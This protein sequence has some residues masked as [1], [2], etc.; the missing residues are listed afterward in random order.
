LLAWLTHEP[1]PHFIQKPQSESATHTGLIETIRYAALNGLL[2]GYV[3]QEP[4]QPKLSTWL[5]ETL[6][7]PAFVL[8]PVPNQ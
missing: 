4:Q 3:S 7:A 6:L 8:T 1:L 2:S 5:M